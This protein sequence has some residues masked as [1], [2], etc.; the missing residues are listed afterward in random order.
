MTGQPTAAIIPGYLRLL[1]PLVNFTGG[2]ALIL[3]AVFSA[4]VFMPKRRVLAYSLDPNQ[5]FDHFLFNLIIAVVAIPVNLVASLPGAL[6]APRVGPHPLAGAGDHPH[7]HRRLHPDHH[8]FPG[9]ARQHRPLLRSASSWASCSCSPASSSRSRSSA[10][11]AS[12][13]RASASRR[14]RRERVRRRDQVARE[15]PRGAGTPVLMPRPPGGGT[16][17][18]VSMNASPARPAPAGVGRGNQTLR[19]AMDRDG[20]VTPQGSCTSTAPDTRPVVAT[21]QQAQGLVPVRGAG[22]A[23]HGALADR[24]FTIDAATDL[25]RAVTRPRSRRAGP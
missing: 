9:R 15:S 17:M 10:R 20:P 16:A 12:R 1:T 21:A 13:S 19:Q 14:A 24:P 4:Y 11:S 23:G 22:P 7:R 25:V 8:R 18:L 6:R 2:L 5:P 3:G